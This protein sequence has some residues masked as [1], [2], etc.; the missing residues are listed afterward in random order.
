MKNPS[1][2][3][4][5][6]KTVGAN[7][8]G[9][10]LEKNWLFDHRDRTF[11]NADKLL[12]LRED[13]RITLTFKGPRQD[14]QFKKREEIELEF[15]FGAPAHSLLGA[16]GMVQWLYYEKLRETW[17]LGPAEIVLDE[18]PELGLFVEIE[19]PTEAE[20]ED[21]VRKLKLPRRYIT[22]TYVQM[23][24]EQGKRPGGYSQE[25]RF[26]PDHRFMLSDE[27]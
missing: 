8:E 12:R 15:P 21:M 26:S 3:R 9:R 13:R 20:I 18:L 24:L 23:L 1:K 5:Q 25:F 10:C 17:R 22:S 27:R 4:E 2:L 6:L 19:A 14:S 7:F 16:I 11:A